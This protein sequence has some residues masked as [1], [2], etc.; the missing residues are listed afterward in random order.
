MRR[1]LLLLLGLA[2]LSIEAHASGGFGCDADDK[3]VSF[4]F[5]SGVTRGMGSP[6]F[7][8][9]GNVEIKAKEVAADLRRLEFDGAHLAQYWS[10][11]GQLNLVIYREREGDKPH[12]YVQVVIRT[13]GDEEGLSGSYELTA[14][15]GVNDATPEGRTYS[16]S[17]KVE[18]IME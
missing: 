13:K 2:A 15:D 5:E 4:L 18:C 14:F 10:E 1:G 6:V 12:G 8:F 11:D 17:G 16:A 9:R 3:N 7:N